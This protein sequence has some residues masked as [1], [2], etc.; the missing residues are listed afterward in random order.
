MNHLEDEIGDSINIIEAQDT[1]SMGELIEDVS[2]GKIK[3]TV[4]DVNFAKLGKLYFKNIDIETPLSLQQNVAFSI[5][6]NSPILLEKLN[7]W[8]ASLQRTGMENI[9]YDKYYKNER[10]IQSRFKSPYLLISSGKISPYDDL[11]KKH[12]VAINW[13]WRLLAA[14]MYRESKFNNKSTSWVGAKGLM[15]LMPNT[16]K[17]YGVKNVFD[18]EQNIKGGIKFIQW[19]EEY[20]N[21]NLIDKNDLNKFVIASYNVGHNHV[22]DAMRLAEKYDMNPEKWSDVS[23]Y[24]LRKSKAKYFH[25]PVVKFGYCRGIEPVQ[26]VDEIYLMYSR[27]K[28]MIE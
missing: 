1:V 26:Y 20:W 24:L 28:D 2:L 15:Q 27:Y 5:R 7:S 4:S 25:D 22:R 10:V 17:S 3:Y 14:L 21:K 11:I 8:I 9:V 18:P 16:A 6:K 23:Y 19:L 12:A 13:D